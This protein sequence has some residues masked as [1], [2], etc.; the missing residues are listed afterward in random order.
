MCQK[1]EPEMEVVSEKMS[2]NI[3]LNDFKTSI[4]YSLG[5]VKDNSYP[6][7]SLKSKKE[8]KNIY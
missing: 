1:L 4:S 7:P 5:Q 3:S 6:C 2:E 8:K